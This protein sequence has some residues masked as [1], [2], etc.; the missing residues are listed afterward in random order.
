LVETTVCPASARRS[1]W[2]N[3]TFFFFNHF[4]AD[5]GISVELRCSTRSAAAAWVS[6]AGA[7]T[8]Y[9]ALAWYRSSYTAL[10]SVLNPLIP[11]KAMKAAARM[12][13]IC[14]S[15]NRRASR[16]LTHDTV[17]FLSTLRAGGV[18]T[19]G[20]VLTSGDARAAAWVSSER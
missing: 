15:V 12:H 5:F 9:R 3:C 11:A 2:T 1:F 20:I 8:T 14:R 17:A 10:A 6:T 16:R 7:P 18:Y 19:S 4:W 13:I